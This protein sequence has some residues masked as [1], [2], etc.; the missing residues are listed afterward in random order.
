MYM[1]ICCVDILFNQNSEGPNISYALLA[2]SFFVNFKKS[3]LFN[4]SKRHRI[5]A[6][7]LLQ[8]ELEGCIQPLWINLVQYYYT[9]DKMCIKTFYITL[10]KG[11]SLV[12]IVGESHGLDMRLTDL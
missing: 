10:A 4:M 1:W 7:D 8:I 2:I 6:A 11:D 5:Y 9:T 12:S 3:F